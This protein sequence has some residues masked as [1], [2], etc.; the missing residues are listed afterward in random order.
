MAAAKDGI[1]ARMR[2]MS[3]DRASPSLTPPLNAAVRRTVVVDG[4]LAFRMRRIE[5]ANNREL[6]LQIYTL[7]QLAARLAGG[8]ARPARAPDLDRAIRDALAEGGLERMEAIKDLPGCPRAIARTLGKVWRA[9]FSLTGSDQPHLTD[10]KLIEDRVRDHLP[11]GVLTQ[12]DLR[13]AAVRNVQHAKQVLGD[14]EL[15]RLCQVAP[16]WR[17]LLEA[18]A[19]ASGLVWRRYR[20]IDAPWFR[21][22]VD[23][24][25]PLP[26]PPIE[27]IA[28]ADPRGE[29]IEALRWV[30]ELVAGGVPPGDIAICAASTES[31]DIPFLALAREAELPLHFSHGLPALVS[32]DGQ[33]CAALADLLLNGLSQERVRRLLTYARGAGRMLRDLPRD[34]NR[35]LKADAALFELQQWRLALDRAVSLRADG[36]D[37]RECLV[38]A[39]ELLDEGIGAADRAGED[40]LGDSAR[41]LWREAMRR[42]PARAL[43]FTLEELRLPDDRDPGTAI[44]WSPADQLVGAPRPYMRL[45]G[46][47]TRTWPRQESEDPLLP[48][49]IVSHAQLGIPSVRTEDQDRF[50]HLLAHAGKACVISR[51]TRDA[52]GSL[53][54]PSPLIAKFE[55][56]VALRRSRVPR[57]A[58]SESDRLL[59]RPAEAAVTPRIASAGSA[60][61]DWRSRAVTPHDG[62]VRAEHPAILRALE[63][64][65]SATSLRL[66]LRDP[67]GFVWHYALGWRSPAQE[68]QPL[69]RDNRSFGELV[70]A[71]LKRAVDKLEPSPGLGRSDEIAVENALGAAVDEIRQEWPLERPVPPTM[72]WNHTLEAARAL[73]FEA[74]TF[75]EPFQDK[76]SRS[77][78]ELAFGQPKDE[79]DNGATPP[80]PATAQVVIPGI[81]MRVRGRIDRLDLAGN[82]RIRLSDYKT[83]IVPQR[84]AKIIL[85]QGRE[86]Q[87]VIYALAARQLLPEIQRVRARLIF[88]AGGEPEAYDLADIDEAFDA[89][90][91]HVAAAVATLGQGTALPGP[92]ALE[93]WNDVRLALPSARASYFR[94]KSAAFAQAF[95]PID[96]IWRAR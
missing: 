92:D 14:V 68:L 25:D 32:R 94:R 96:F 65:Q 36:V 50:H 44:V 79:L 38:P 73:A 42:G 89:L 85:D 30:R 95:R 28:C 63:A 48:S 76:D 55:N 56:T 35:H 91:S 1:G 24:I 20:D 93:D 70:H 77:W 57:H 12:R 41:L 34:W 39:L 43:M 31:W 33:A 6:G 29:V 27:S 19:G 67:L 62:L 26:S 90:S 60:W 81:G 13:D 10:L 8:Y 69:E 88:L 83:G 9:D 87:R 52:R 45:L 66:L 5:A 53:L 59:A 74:L 46:L 71:L 82:G 78:T 17:P 61:H 7:A 22:K 58:F 2:I 49:H 37:P 75:D 3:R 51:S 86:L 11:P 80:W 16:L 15:D 40:L 4:P 64:P 18:I 21:G 54:A 47:T 23:V 72:L 84:V